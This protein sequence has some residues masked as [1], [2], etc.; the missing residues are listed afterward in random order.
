MCKVAL[1]EAAC[2]TSQTYEYA[3]PYLKLDTSRPVFTAEAPQAF[4]LGQEVVRYQEG[5][6]Q[7]NLCDA[8]LG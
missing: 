4:H 8:Q 2:R 1:A 5:V 6:M 3:I 7:Y